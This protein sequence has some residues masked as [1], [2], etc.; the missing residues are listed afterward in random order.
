[1]SQ[2]VTDMGRL[3]LDLGPIKSDLTNFIGIS[4]HMLQKFCF[5]QMFFEA[6]D[7]GDGVDGGDAGDR[8]ERGDGGEAGDRVM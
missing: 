7:K 3:W 2:S 6:G 5:A 4:D 1:M 8:G